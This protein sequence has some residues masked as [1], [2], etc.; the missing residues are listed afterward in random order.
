MSPEE[1]KYVDLLE[2]HKK[3]DTI[4]I[5][6]NRT[7]IEKVGENRSVMIMLEVLQHKYS[8]TKGEKVLDLIKILV[9]LRQKRKLRC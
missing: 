3:N 2:S 6:V 7:I 4:K 9:D 1:D 5:Y 8:Q